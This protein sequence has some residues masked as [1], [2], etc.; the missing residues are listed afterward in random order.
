MVIRLFAEGDLKKADRST[1]EA[2]AFIDGERRAVFVI[3]DGEHLRA[4]ANSCP[5]RWVELNWQPNVFLSLDG[6]DIQCTAH[7]A[8]F[9]IENGLCISGP[10]A[11]MRLEA[12]AVSAKEGWIVLEMPSKKS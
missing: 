2:Q 12:F 3:R 6:L 1:C 10:C 9:L 7:G 11:G 8:R 4:Y 5:H